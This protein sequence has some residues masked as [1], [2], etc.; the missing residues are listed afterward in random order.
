LIQGLASLVLGVL[1]L[2]NDD[3]NPSFTRY[4]SFSFNKILLPSFRVINNIM[5]KKRQSIQTI[6]TKRIGADE[7]LSKLNALRDSD[8][9]KH[10]SDLNTVFSFFLSF[11]LSPFCFKYKKKIEAGEK[12]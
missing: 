10:F 8:Y 9:I 6:I 11:F 5:K 3:S 1:I 2:Y 4:L 12:C 7:F